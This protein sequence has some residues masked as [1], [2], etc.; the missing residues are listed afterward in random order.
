MRIARYVFSTAAADNDTFRWFIKVKKNSTFDQIVQFMANPPPPLLCLSLPAK[1]EACAIVQDWVAR[2]NWLAAQEKS[3][4]HG[5]IET[6]KQRIQSAQ[7]NGGGGGGG[8]GSDSNTPS[9]NHIE[10]AVPPV[11]P[12]TDPIDFLHEMEQNIH[13]GGGFRTPPRQ[14]SAS[15][16]GG[17]STTGFDSP[18]AQGHG[19][20]LDSPPAHGGEFGGGSRVGGGFGTRP[21][22]S[23]PVWS[24]PAR[25]S[26]PP[27]GGGSSGG[28]FDSHGGEF[29]GGGSVGGGPESGPS[30][31]R[32]RFCSATDSSLNTLP[33]NGGDEFDDLYWDEDDDDVME[34]AATTTATAQFSYEAGDRHTNETNLSEGEVVIVLQSD[35]GGWMNVQSASGAGFVPTSYLTLN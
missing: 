29:R 22:W 11:V 4:C 30:P 25:G 31:A 26:A 14:G 16:G 21:I 5:I 15:G 27:G 2:R 18:P 1:V 24:P 3:I 13:S 28:G 20:G 35:S 9:R 34:V 12:P 17:G 32:I 6:T 8:G 33:P 10:Q 7:S 19:G 23:P